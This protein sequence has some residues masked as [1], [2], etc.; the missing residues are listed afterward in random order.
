VFNP[1]QFA[2][3]V[4]ERVQVSRAG[5][6]A[7]IQKTNAEGFCWLLRLRHSP[8]HRECEN[9]RENPHQFSILNTSASFNTSFGFPIIG[10]RTHCSEA[11]HFIHALSFPNRKSE[12]LLLRLT[13]YRTDVR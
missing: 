10:A 9:D 12:F 8:T 3:L 4:P 1:A 2:Q 5:S 7:S 6:R 11:R 13:P